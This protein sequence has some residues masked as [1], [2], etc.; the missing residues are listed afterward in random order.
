MTEP[1]ETKLR[2]N[3]T[4]RQKSYLKEKDVINIPEQNKAYIEEVWYV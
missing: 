2:E 1:I 3:L 4:E